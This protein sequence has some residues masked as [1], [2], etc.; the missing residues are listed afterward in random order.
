MGGKRSQSQHQSGILRSK[1]VKPEISGK[2]V[3]RSVF[4]NFAGKL[5]D[6][7]KVGLVVAP[8]GYGKSTLLSQSF[9]LL[10]HQGVHCAWLSLDAQDNDPLRFMSHFLTTLSTLASDDFQFGIDHLGA[11]SKTITDS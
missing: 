6:R 8:A 4:M 3:P 1:L 11:G 10:E 9:E 2:L 5:L 7:V